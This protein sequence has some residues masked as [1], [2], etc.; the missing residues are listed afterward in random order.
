MGL[1]EILEGAEDGVRLLRV[2]C[3][4][5]GVYVSLKSSVRSSIDCV[6]RVGNISSTVA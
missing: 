3:D 4:I 2:E 1:S 6:C 5:L